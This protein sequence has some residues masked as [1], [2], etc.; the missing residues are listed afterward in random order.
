[1]HLS[2][3]YASFVKWSNFPPIVCFYTIIRNVKGYMVPTKR[4]GR[5]Y[6]IFLLILP[7]HHLKYKQITLLSGMDADTA[8][9]CTYCKAQLQ[10]FG[11]HK[12]AVVPVVL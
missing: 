11:N 7:F 9:I 2:C 10:V 1:M 4:N 6:V 5:S 3:T 12:M 8:N